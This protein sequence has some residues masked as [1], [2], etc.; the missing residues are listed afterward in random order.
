MLVQPARAAGLRFE[1]DAN[2]RNRLS[3]VLQEAA[4]KDPG[5]LPLLQFTL[6]ELFKRRTEQGVLTFAA[7]EELGGLEGALSRRAEE[8]FAGLPLEV[9]NELPSVLRALVT[10]SEERDVK[11]GAR[12]APLSSVASS[13]TRRQLVEAFI[14][15]RLLVR[16]GRNRRV[17]ESV[18][19]VAHEALL[20]HWPRVQ[21]WLVEDMEFLR[22]RGRVE[23]RRHAGPKKNA[24]RN[25]FCAKAGPSSKGRIY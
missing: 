6:D 12:R 4:G 11:V 2:T 24:D 25:I 13:E 15:A 22:A 16:R 7:Y 1:V 9:Q 10:V 3:D 17:H 14:A 5:A 19:R 20:R 23:I 8:V 21:Q 18:V